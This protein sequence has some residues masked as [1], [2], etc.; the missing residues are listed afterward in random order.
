MKLE[1]SIDHNELVAE[2]SKEVIKALKPMLK[3]E[4]EDEC[5]YTVKT[6]AKYLNVSTQWIYERTQFKTIPH[7]KVG[8]HLRFKRN[9]IDCWLQAQHIK[10][11]V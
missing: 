8:H 2:I 1:I 10:S 11:T 6:L 4:K 3:K 7:Y 9:D 5:I